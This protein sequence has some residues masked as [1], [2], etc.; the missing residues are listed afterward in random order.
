MWESNGITGEGPGPPHVAGQYSGLLVL[1][2][3]ADCIWHDLQGIAAMFD[4]SFGPLWEQ[5]M[6][7]AHYMAVNDIG[8]YWQGEL[9]HWLTLHPNYM[10]GWMKFRMG[11]NFGLGHG[12]ET[13]SNKP[14]EGIDNVWAIANSGGSGGLF[15]CLVAL[16]LGYNRIILAGMPIDESRHFFDAPWYHGVPLNGR[17]QEMV[18][19]EARDREFKDRVRSMSGRTRQWLGH[20]AKE[21]IREEIAL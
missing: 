5:G 13:H 6:I 10:P 17:P 3:G 8:A 7:P 16:A 21:W 1:M 14:W 9:H 15:A 11:H 19:N 18:W 4:K 12:V 20:P 2:G